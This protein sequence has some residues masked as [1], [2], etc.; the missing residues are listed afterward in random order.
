MLTEDL[1]TAVIDISSS[2]DNEIIE[3]Q[4]AGSYIAIDHINFIVTT[5]VGVKFVSSGQSGDTDLSGVYPFD[6]KQAMAL[7]NAMNAEKGVIICK[8]NES[9]LINLDDAVQV[10]GFIRYRIINN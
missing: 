1:K 5:A 9:F 7:D 6:T 3:E 10:S 4:G 8:E 2:G